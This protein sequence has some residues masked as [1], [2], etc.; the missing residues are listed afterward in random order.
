MS[1]VFFNPVS[2][3]QGHFH[4]DGYQNIRDYI[5]VQILGLRRSC[6]E[7]GQIALDGAKIQ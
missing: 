2:S 1:Y 7:M 3:I 5:F 6:Y 4:K